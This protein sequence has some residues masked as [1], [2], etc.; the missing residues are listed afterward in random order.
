MSIRRGPLREFADA[1]KCFFWMLACV[2][3]VDN[4]SDYAAVVDDK[5]SPG[6]NEA[7]FYVGSVRL[8]GIVVRPIAEKGKFDTE[9]VGE[10]SGGKWGVHTDAQDLG[11]G[12]RQFILHIAE[13]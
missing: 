1:A 6:R 13:A 5:G 9:F 3:L 2:G 10:G 11:T 4:G 12:F 7:L 8:A